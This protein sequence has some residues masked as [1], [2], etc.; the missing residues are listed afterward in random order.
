VLA[1][2]V[3]VLIALNVMIWQNMNMDGGG[4]VVSVAFI[5]LVS[6]LLVLPVVLMAYAVVLLSRVASAVQRI[7]RRQAEQAEPA[8]V[9][10]DIPLI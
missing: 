3:C 10:D 4:D 1:V 5:V 7:E 9:E 8:S 6:V 2:A